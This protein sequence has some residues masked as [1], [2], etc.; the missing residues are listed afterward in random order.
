MQDVL[1]LEHPVC[2]IYP[3]T[4]RLDQTVVRSF[5]ATGSQSTAVVSGSSLRPGSVDS[6]R[7]PS[8][9]SVLGRM[10]FQGD[11]QIHLR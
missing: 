4:L 1:A 7:M 9:Y 5:S 8:H 6:S 2:S 11:K 3:G 10:H